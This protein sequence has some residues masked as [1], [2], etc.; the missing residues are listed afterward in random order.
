MSRG[1]NVPVP[2]FRRNKRH[3]Q[4]MAE[5]SQKVFGMKLRRGRS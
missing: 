3:K 2:R 1:A 5:N 4:R